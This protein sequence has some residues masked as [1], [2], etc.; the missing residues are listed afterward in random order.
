METCRTILLILHST[1]PPYWA[2]G[3]PGIVLSGV[4][5]TKRKDKQYI[6]RTE[7]KN[8][9]SVIPSPP[10]SLIPGLQGTM[11]RNKVI[12]YCELNNEIYFGYP[13]TAD[14]CMRYVMFGLQMTIVRP[15]FVTRKGNCGQRYVLWD[16]RRSLIPPI[17]RS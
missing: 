5:R 3:N 4:K 16:T 7:V 8:V 12:Y 6:F 9:C 15:G 10:R 13:C 14:C 11:F 2:N 17:Q 1:E